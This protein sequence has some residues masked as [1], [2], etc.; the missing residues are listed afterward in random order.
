MCFLTCLIDW[1]PTSYSGESRSTS[2][3]WKNLGS[4]KEEI[5]RSVERASNSHLIYVKRPMGLQLILSGL[6]LLP[7]ALDLHTLK[8]RSTQLDALA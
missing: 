4:D 7:L 2:S 8:M 5:K 3:G 1:M 6:L